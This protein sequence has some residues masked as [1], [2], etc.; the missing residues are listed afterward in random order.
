M[1]RA[2]PRARKSAPD[3]VQNAPQN[4][5]LLDC[6]RSVVRGRPLSSARNSRQKVGGGLIAGHSRFDGRGTGSLV[7]LTGRGN[8]HTHTHTHAR[9][10]TLRS[11]RLTDSTDRAD[12]SC[13]CHPWAHGHATRCTCGRRPDTSYRVPLPHAGRYPFPTYRSQC[14]GS[15]TF[16]VPCYYLPSRLT[17]QRTTLPAPHLH[18]S[19]T[20][21][22]LHWS[23]LS[24]SHVLA[25]LWTAHFFLS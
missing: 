2:R 25:D 18:L 11:D 6:A 5:Q 16:R 20:C 15:S 4:P 17:L 9:T 22:C 3:A 24:P 1:S 13:F 12:R 23:F 21:I 7:S 8:A 14:Q 10:H 19:S